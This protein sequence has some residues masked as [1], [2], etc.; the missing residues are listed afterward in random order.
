MK[1]KRTYKYRIYPNQEQKTCLEKWLEICRVLYNDCLTERRDAWSVAHKSIS[2]YDQANQLKEIK[3]F[4]EDLKKVYSQVLQ[5]VLKRVDKAFKNFFRRIKRR[6]KAGYP[7]YK[8]RSR[9]SS[10][11]YPQDGFKFSEDDKK[12]ILSKIGSINIKKHRDIPESANIKTCTI[13]KDLDRWYACFSVEIEVKESSGDQDK[14]I[15]N[16]IGIDLGINHLITLSNGEIIDNPRYLSKS[17]LKIKR[18]QRKLNKSKKGS[19]NRKKRR[20]ELA[21]AH[22]K[23]KDQRTDLLHKISRSLVNAYDLIIFEGLKVKN[24]MKNHYL[25]KSIN[26]ASWSRLTNFVS[27]KAEEAGKIV[28]F[29]DPKNTSQECSSCGKIVKK[30]L[31][32]RVHKCP[33]CGLEMDRDQNAAINILR[34]GLQNVGQGLS[35]FKP[36]EFLK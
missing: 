32:Q 9:Y 24:M 7:R 29:V 19:N 33:F 17:E 14:E 13:E 25:A 20:F 22:R 1:I 2:Y 30:S 31:N 15:T 21:K 16:P 6:E 4:D 18:R 12:L 11:T 36:A 8:P 26:D 28:E 10:F 27:Y 35:E 5:D 23:V 3:T 34:K